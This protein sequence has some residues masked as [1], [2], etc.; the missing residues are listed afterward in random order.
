MEELFEIRESTM[1]PIRVSIVGAS[2]YGA[3]ELLRRLLPDPD[4]EVLK[5]ISK[6]DVG[7]HLNE[8]HLSLAESGAEHVIEDLPVEEAAEGADLVFLGLPHRVS[9][10]FAPRI[11]AKGVKLIDLS[12]DFRL[13]STEDYARYY[14]L[15]HT[16]PE[17]IERFVYGL[18]ELYRDAIKDANAVASPGC[19]ATSQIL[20]L[21][22]LARRGWL[23]TAVRVVSA[24][25]SSGSG[26]NPSKG[27]HHPL[28]SVTLRPYRPLNHQHTPEI[29]QALS[30]AGA[31][32]MRLDFVPVSAPLSRGILTTALLDLPPHVGPEDVRAAYSDDYGD[33]RF[34]RLVE[35]RHPEVASVKGSQYVEI[36][37]HFDE[38]RLAVFC[39]LD[40]LVKGGAGQA[41]QSFNIMMGRPEH[42]GLT[43]S[44]TWP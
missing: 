15:E 13:R 44:P 4:V 23:N 22:P 14:G 21:A 43:A 37:H 10:D 20:P 3:A 17:L 19:F 34:I 11:L 38:G 27:T 8:V 30:D 40:N 18:P 9:M 26:A 35:G 29:V 16:A 28:R 25:G 24:T 39:A 36:G 1:S 32:E 6:D 41:I 42:L 7:K 5:L 2:G 31:Q 12:G 33:E